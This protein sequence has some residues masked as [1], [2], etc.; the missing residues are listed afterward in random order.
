M[1]ESAIDLDLIRTYDQTASVL[2]KRQ[3][4]SFCIVVKCQ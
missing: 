1:V 4:F 3:Q 2:C